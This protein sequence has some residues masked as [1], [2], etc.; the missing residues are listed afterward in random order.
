MKK[1]QK[2]NDLVVVVVSSL[3]RQNYLTP[4]DYESF[5]E[6]GGIEYTAD[7]IWGLQLQIIN[8]DIFGKDTNLKAKREKIKQAKNAKPRDIEFVCLKNRYGE[9]NYT[10]RFQYFAEYDYFKPV[11]E[12]YY[13]SS[14]YNERL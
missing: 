2:D 8:D 11:D 14:F 5:K 13:D 10:C 4:V 12:Q 3:N 9:S 7:V 1:L 6:S